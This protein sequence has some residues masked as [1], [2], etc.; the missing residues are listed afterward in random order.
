MVTKVSFNLKL[1]EEL[2]T[3]GGGVGLAG[4]GF[5]LEHAMIQTDK[6]K[7]RRVF[8]SVIMGLL[9]YIL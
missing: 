9:R 2:S 3:W 6:M 1:I 4:D 7:R 8:I 5:S